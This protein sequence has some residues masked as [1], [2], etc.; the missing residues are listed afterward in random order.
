MEIAQEVG[1]RP[2]HGLPPVPTL[3]L[4]SSLS[5]G[6]HGSQDIPACRLLLPRRSGPQIE[7]CVD[8]AALYPD[9]GTM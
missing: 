4:S 5:P 6:T 9:D 1:G 8:G 2:G 3:S 7:M